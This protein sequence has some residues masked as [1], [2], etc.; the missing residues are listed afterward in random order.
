MV[1]AAQYNDT[2]HKMVENGT[3][4]ITGAALLFLNGSSLAGVAGG[5][6]A[7]NLGL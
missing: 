4:P 7:G 3:E 6:A 2:T 5:F 1:D